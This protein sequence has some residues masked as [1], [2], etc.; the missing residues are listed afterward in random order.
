[1][2]RL[3]LLTLTGVLLLA[4]PSAGANPPDEHSVLADKLTVQVAL[5]KAR[6]YLYYDRDPGRAVEELEKHLA[7]IDGNRAY[8]ELLRDAYR[9]YCLKLCGGGADQKALAAKYRKRLEILDG[10]AA[11]DPTLQAAFQ[12]PRQ[13]PTNAALAAMPPQPTP[14]PAAAVKPAA[15]PVKAPA[16][17]EGYQARGQ[18]AD[19]FDAA[20]QM[21]PLAAAPAA[22]GQAAT[23]LARA[24]AEYRAQHYAAARLL[25]EQAHHA[26]PQAT[27]QC[28]ERWAFCKLFC[29]VEALYVAKGQACAWED[30]E[31]EVHA[32]YTLAPHLKTTC[33][34]LLGEIGKRRG[35]ATAAGAVAV[36]HTSASVQGWLLAETKNFRVFHKQAP[37]V[38]EKVA[39]AAEATRAATARKWFGDTGPDWAPKC[40][41]FLHNTAA[42]YVQLSKVAPGTPGHSRIE[43]DRTTHQV[44]SRRIDLHC[45]GFNW[46]ETVLPHETTHV[47]IAGQFGSAQVP[48]WA[49]EGIAVL[50]EPAAVQEKHRANLLKCLK[51]GGGAFPVSDLMQ[52]PN[53][54][55]AERVGAFYAQ[56]VSLVD[57]LSKQRG[58]QVFS[59][60]LR[61][62]VK[63]GYPRALNQHY[64]F[65]D[66]ADLQG[67]WV[68]YV[69][70]TLPS[71]AIAK[72]Q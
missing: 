46:L 7:I 41:I 54:P 10:A 17:T 49:D 19:P 40:D 18:V 23:L 9:A 48:R 35:G 63:Q 4:N 36:Q 15:A 61:D 14:Q 29:V 53:Y 56:S 8:L 38:A 37:E 32:A 28:R 39:R 70:S 27:A 50:S 66:F 72:Q 67:R 1:M 65:T 16:V 57:Y 26:D 45:E 34:D 68:N 22:R 62:A 64:G 58:P 21:P 5:G 55:A 11:T 20:N 13:A 69:Q 59:Q 6:N 3:T 60:F 31:K 43:C 12:A 71:S 25:F 51:Q 52:L 44:V 2:T 47:V 24:E 30:L 33:T 42:E